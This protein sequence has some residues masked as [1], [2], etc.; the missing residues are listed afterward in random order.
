MTVCDQSQANQLR[1][2][3]EGEKNRDQKDEKK[4]F[5]VLSTGETKKKGPRKKTVRQKKLKTNQGR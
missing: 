4:I 5:P 1:E 2:Y 3:D